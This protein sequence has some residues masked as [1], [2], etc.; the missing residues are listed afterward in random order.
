MHC[1]ECPAFLFRLR[2]HSDAYEDPT[3]NGRL[4]LEALS[5]Q[6]EALIRL[7]LEAQ[8]LQLEAL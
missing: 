4:Q 3:I 1:A 2:W 7:Q 6:L 5:L 8:R